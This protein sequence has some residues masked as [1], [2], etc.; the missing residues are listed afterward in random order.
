MVY[1]GAGAGM[2]PLRAH[3][4]HLLETEQ[5]ARKVTFWYGARSEQEIFYHDYFSIWPINTLL[6]FQPGAFFTVTPR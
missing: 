2:A 3:L 4:S 1:I 6:C 5:C